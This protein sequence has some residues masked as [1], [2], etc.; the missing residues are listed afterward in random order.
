MANKDITNMVEKYNVF[1]SEI[2][3]NTNREAL[4][5]REVEKHQCDEINEY[6][7]I[8]NEH[9]VREIY[10]DENIEWVSII[11]DKK[12]DVCQMTTLRCNYEDDE[13]NGFSFPVLIC[14]YCGEV[15]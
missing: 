12:T 11:K 8:L 9:P 3:S 2:L 4:L 15:L 6:N 1:L 10:E 14:P 7:R 13:V 5:S